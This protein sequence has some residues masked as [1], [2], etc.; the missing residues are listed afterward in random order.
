MIG[1]N[2]TVVITASGIDGDGNRFAG[3]AHF[4]V[5]S[6]APGNGVVTFRIDIGWDSPLPTRTDVLVCD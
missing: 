1:I 4:Q 2:P 5:S 3:G 6:I